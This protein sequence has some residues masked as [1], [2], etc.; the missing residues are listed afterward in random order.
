[1]FLEILRLERSL[2]NLEVEKRRDYLVRKPGRRLHPLLLIHFP[3]KQCLGKMIT[4]VVLRK[5]LRTLL[6]RSYETLGPYGSV[7]NSRRCR[8]LT[9]TLTRSVSERTSS[10]R[11][12]SLNFPLL[13]TSP[14]TLEFVDGSQ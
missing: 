9:L 8:T 12:G 13:N 14:R 3:A 10:T 2:H 7:R 5:R 11:E 1:M 6:S 4:V